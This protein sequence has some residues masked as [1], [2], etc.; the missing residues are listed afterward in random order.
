MQRV[1]IGQESSWGLTNGFTQARER[2]LQR[3]GYNS[4]KISFK[5]ATS[6]MGK[7]R[8]HKHLFQTSVQEGRRPI[9]PLC[10]VI[11]W[12]L[13]STRRSARWSSLLEGTR[14]TTLAERPS[15]DIAH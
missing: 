2:L 1:L 7:L 6:C 8:V 12:P 10:V 14:L 5:R 15:T 11:R 3:L 4:F 9:E 13:M